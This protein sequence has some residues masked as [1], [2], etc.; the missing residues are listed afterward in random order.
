VQEEGDSMIVLEATKE[1]AVVRL[2]NDELWMVNAALNEV[3][4]GVHAL[5]DDGELQTR[6]GYH[7]AELRQLLA[8]IHP[9]ARISN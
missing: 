4:N 5:G 6:T 2:T 3:C 9:L 7:R 1:G 8:E